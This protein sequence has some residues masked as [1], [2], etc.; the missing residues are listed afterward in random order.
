MD[1][2]RW[3]VDG[4]RWSVVGGKVIGYGL[5]GLRFCLGSDF[6]R[7]RSDLRVAGLPRVPRGCGYDKILGK[8]VDFT[9][10]TKG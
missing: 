9:F 7:L 8:V 4:G 3:T 6:W 10:Q 1:G 2:G 5:S